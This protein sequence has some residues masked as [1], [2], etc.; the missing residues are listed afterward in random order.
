MESG[1]RA[2]PL[3]PAPPAQPRHPADATVHPRRYG[4][5]YNEAAGIASAAPSF[6]ELLARQGRMSNA[7]TMMPSIDHPAVCRFEPG[8]VADI[9][10]R[11]PPLFAPPTGLVGA[12]PNA[13]ALPNAVA[14][15]DAVVVAPGTAV[16]LEHRG[17]GNEAVAATAPP[18]G[19][20]DLDGEVDS[21]RFP[22]V[23]ATQTGALPIA[24]EFGL[25]D[26]VRSSGTIE[27][28]VYF[29]QCMSFLANKEKIKMI[30]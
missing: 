8:T 2:E 3:L 27:G 25:S 21:S 19:T 28:C 24:N 29:S 17:A 16:E 10:R 4:C 11:S 22:C 23:P 30:Y 5:G 7:G 20:A 6:F 13:V 18:P 26:A 9:A 12:V 1:H 14:S 15:P